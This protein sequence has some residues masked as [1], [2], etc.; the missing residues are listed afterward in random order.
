MRS[1]PRGSRRRCISVG[2]IALRRSNGKVRLAAVAFEA[3]ICQSE[4]SSELVEC[5]R[6]TL[7][8]WLRTRVDVEGTHAMR[9]CLVSV[10][11]FSWNSFDTLLDSKRKA[12]N[13]TGHTVWDRCRIGN[14]ALMRG[15]LEKKTH[16]LD[17]FLLLALHRKSVED[18]YF[19]FQPYYFLLCVARTTRN[20]NRPNREAITTSSHPK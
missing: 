7:G 2:G 19:L 4:T 15:E 17:R 3:R 13:Q 16:R 5:G 6:T 8:P 11:A 1:L 12:A 10:V 18:S 20:A 14:R 9:V